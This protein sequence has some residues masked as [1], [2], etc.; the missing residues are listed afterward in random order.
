MNYID[1]QVNGTMGVDFN[2]DQLTPDQM[3]TVCSRLRDDGIAQFLPTIITDTISAMSSRLKRL[4]ELREADPLVQQLVAGFHIEGPF[5]NETEG[6]IGA[7]PVKAVRPANRDDMQR[8]LDAAAGLTRIVTLAPERDEG[9]GVTG[10]LADAEICVSAGHC[11]PTLDQLK[12]AIDAGLAM[13]THL[14]N[15]CPAEMHRHDNI[16]Q[17]VLSLADRLWISF[18]ADGYHIPTFVLKNY[19]RSISLERCV[20]VTD[21]I[22]AAGLGPGRFQVGGQTFLVGE[23]GIPRT[24]DGKYFA[25]SGVTTPKMVQFAR[26]ELGLTAE[27]IDLLMSANPRRILNA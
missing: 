27:E 18:I 26:D 21:A 16:I 3:H 14:G 9:F 15:G 24:G 8:L 20:L 2:S 1:L 5:L 10:M 11:D 12:G 25:G 7:H 6:Y 22:S 4:V 19:L 13:F 17:R 23:D